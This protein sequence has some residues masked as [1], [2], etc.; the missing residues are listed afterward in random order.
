MSFATVVSQGYFVSYQ[1]DHAQYR[2]TFCGEHHIPGAVC[3]NCQTS[4]LRILSIDLADPRFAAVSSHGDVLHLLFCWTCNISAE[5]FY[6]QIQDNGAVQLLA[7]GKDGCVDDFPYEAY[8][9]Y[10]PETP[11]DFSPID[12]AEQQILHALNTGDLDEDDLDEEQEYLCAPQHQIGGEPY[13]IDPEMLEE[14]IACVSCHHPM[15]FLAAVADGNRDERGFTGNPYV[16]LLFF[17][18]D[19]CNT[20]CAVQRCD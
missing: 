12:A 11:V 5:P 13:M 16:Q 1:R 4:L 20:I 8:P 7:Y 14:E 3:P 9:T 2:H 19:T 15:R 17:Y 18:C 10:F 6:Y